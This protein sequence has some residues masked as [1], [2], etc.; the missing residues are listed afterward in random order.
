MKAVFWGVLLACVDWGWG[1]ENLTF[2]GDVRDFAISDRSV[3]VVT[4]DRLYQLNHD[5]TKVIKRDTPNVVYPNQEAPL[6]NETYPFKVNILLPFIKNN[7]L[8]TCGTTKCG[9]CEILDLN[10]I[11]K[12]VH[13]ENIE[14]GSLDPGDSTIGFI[15]DVGTNSY[16]MTGRL[17]SRVRKACANSDHL[18]DLRNTLEGQHGGIFS[19][20]DESTTPYI[21]ARQKEK[22]QFVDGFQSN[23]HIYVFSNVPQERQVRVIL[24]K[25]EN[26]KTKTLGNFQGA[27]LKCCGNTE[28]RELLSSSVIQG[29]GGLH[30][31]VLWAG[32]F[33]AGNTSDPINTV[34]AIYN[35]SSTGPQLK[36]KDP[37]FCYKGCAEV[38][39][40]NGYHSGPASRGGGV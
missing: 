28:R 11:S 13:S 6:F 20:S 38:G 5:F 37:D 17:Q 16:I 24:F 33:T 32:V 3:Y 25:S 23:S 2:D 18:L 14:V 29:S 12:S 9:Y 7:T 39:I 34:L 19:Y 31:Q 27:T 26:S 1:Q 10:E 4:D 22:F 30:G 21:D 35:I 40:A 15:V 8:I 36:Y